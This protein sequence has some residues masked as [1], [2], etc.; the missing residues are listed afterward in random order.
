MTTISSH[1]LYCSSG[2]LHLPYS[3]QL[4]DP[5][6]SLLRQR[7]KGLGSW[8]FFFQHVNP[9]S[10][11]FR[12]RKEQWEGVELL[13]LALN[14]HGTRLAVLWNLIPKYSGYFLLDCL[15]YD[16]NIDVSSHLLI[17]IT[18]SCFFSTFYFPICY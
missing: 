5:A 10:E 2:T 7:R 17:Q 6:E 1:Q 13:H 18:V 3:M 14:C 9:V 4:A 8:N 11:I 12:D 16:V 15:L